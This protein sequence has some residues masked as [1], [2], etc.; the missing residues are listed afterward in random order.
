M[1]ICSVGIL[2]AF[3]QYYVQQRYPSVGS[4]D[5]DIFSIQSI[6]R[7][8]LLRNPPTQKWLANKKWSHEYLIH[9][10]QGKKSIQYRN[11]PVFVHYDTSLKLADR[12]PPNYER[13]LLSMKELFDRILSSA[14]DGSGFYFNDQ[15]ESVSKPLLHDL[16]P[17][18]PLLINDPPTFPLENYDHVAKMVKLWI[19]GPTGLVANLHYDA[20]HNIFHQVSGSKRFT[21]LSPDKWK[22]LS[23]YSR[24][25]PSHRQS[26]IIGNR[27]ALVALKP[28]EIVLKPGDTLYLPPFWFHQVE[29][30]EPSVSVNV[31]SN[32]K[33]LNDLQHALQQPLPYLSE[34][35]R[36][37]YV[38]DSDSHV[39]YFQRFILQLVEKTI[40]YPHD[41]MKTIIDNA[42][43]QLP[44]S[45]ER[46]SCGKVSENLQADRRMQEILS[47]WIEK[48]FK[49]MNQD[50]R[51]ILVASFIES[52]TSEF[53]RPDLVHI[54][55]QKCILFESG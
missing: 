44:A 38:F 27:S 33:T 20:T 36:D 15:I 3:Y 41:F 45:R 35:E 46:I 5:W 17:L 47:E 55:L 19:G 16:A 6:D 48:S 28:F 50:S 14:D 1:V 22:Y 40:D 30:L 8:V 29:T 2:A 18:A 10:I 32:S 23:V 53:V 54:F 12:F 24:L 37:G 42:K 9:E 31:W 21:L 43:L 51:W 4:I 52:I 7:P 39:Y 11:P 49:P 13:K 25:H 34:F 26:Q